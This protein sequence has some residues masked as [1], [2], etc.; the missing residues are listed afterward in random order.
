MLLLF[1]AIFT[2]YSLAFIENPSVTLISLVTCVDIL[3]TMDIVVIFNS[4]Y[5]NS[6]HTLIKTH[7]E[8]ARKYLSTWFVIDLLSW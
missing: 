6:E 4:A 8:I 7:K 2:P 1:T 3:F 5:Y